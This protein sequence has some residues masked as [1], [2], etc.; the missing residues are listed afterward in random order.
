MLNTIYIY[1]ISCHTTTQIDNTNHINFSMN[2]VTPNPIT[3]TIDHTIPVSISRK[4]QALNRRRA[5]IQWLKAKCKKD[6]QL[7][8]KYYTEN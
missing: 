5:K 2:P 4:L 3:F 6:K 7:S 1:R 8:T